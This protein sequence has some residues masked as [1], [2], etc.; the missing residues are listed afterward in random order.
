MMYLN[1]ICD[2]AGANSKFKRV[3]RG[4]GSGKG[5]T[6]GRGMKGQKSRSGVAIK[7]FA[8]GQ[9]PLYR[10]FAYIGFNNKNFR[11]N[12][13]I[14]NLSKI[15]KAIK[16][17]IIDKD[18]NIDVLLNAGLINVKSGFSGL[19]VLGFGKISSAISIEVDKISQSAKTAIEAAQG[20]VFIKETVINTDDKGRFV[21]KAVK[22]EESIA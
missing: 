12:Y 15:E 16:D 10:R 20:K 6:C 21:K 13:A 19:K 17:K 11:K 4:V 9:M 8:G 1:N 14:I 2:N 22:K 5:K 18:I 7:N 3:G